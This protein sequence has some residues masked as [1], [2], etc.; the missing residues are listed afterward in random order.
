MLVQGSMMFEF[1]Y[2]RNK[3]NKVLSISFKMIECL[4]TMGVDGSGLEELD[5]GLWMVSSLWCLNCVA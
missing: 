5:F 3:Q 4:F 2:S 1:S